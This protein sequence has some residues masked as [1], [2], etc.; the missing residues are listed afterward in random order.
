[1]PMTAVTPKKRKES[2]TPLA[3]HQVFSL[4]HRHQH[5]VSLLAIEMAD[6]E[7]LSADIGA[8]RM[9]TLFRRLASQLHA[10]KRCEDL[11]ITHGN[12]HTLLMVLPATPLSGG[13]DLARRLLARLAGTETQLDEFQV[14][15]SLRIA[16][17][18]SE[19]L[20]NPD[21]QP[22]IETTLALLQ[23]QV[24]GQV[25]EKINGQPLLLSKTAKQALAAPGKPVDDLVANLV[26]QATH[27]GGQALLDSL[28][29][30]LSRLA[31][32]DR[33]KLVDHLLNLSIRLDSRLS[34]H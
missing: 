24:K 10:L 28:K 29:P 11:L 23:G 3:I 34:R 9:D 1:M 2:H 17:H 16:L 20:E 27:K 14:E 22:L 6:R 15:I 19:R 8:S 12:S 26:T 4:C 13:Q 18:G 32:C 21:P 33:L 5:P 31:E 30:A 25:K 7:N